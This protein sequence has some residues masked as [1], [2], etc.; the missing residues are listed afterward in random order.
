LRAKRARKKTIPKGYKL[1]FKRVWK[2]V[3]RSSSE[4]QITFNNQCIN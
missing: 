3:N 4:I 1:S 2:Q